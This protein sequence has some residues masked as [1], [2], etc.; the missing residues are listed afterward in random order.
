MVGLGGDPKNIQRVARPI[1][2]T[3]V[4]LGSYCAVFSRKGD[5]KTIF[6]VEGFDDG[7]GAGL[8]PA[9]PCAHTEK[10]ITTQVSVL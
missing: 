6:A 8:H 3:L 2:Q 9:G 7:S 5:G 10:N 1:A 4:L